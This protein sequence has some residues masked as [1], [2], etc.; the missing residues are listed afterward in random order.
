M[1]EIGVHSSCVT[2]SSKAC[3][4]ASRCQLT[5]SHLRHL[6]ITSGLYTLWHHSPGPTTALS[7]T[8]P[9]GGRLYGNDSAE[10][11]IAGQLINA[12]R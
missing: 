5:G 6:C 4:V 7:A 8:P 12:S 11:L 9:C 3:K 1:E 2:Q 10:I